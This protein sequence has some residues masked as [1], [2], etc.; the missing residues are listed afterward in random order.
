MAT[1]SSL[2]IGSGVNVSSLISG[3]MA[4]EQAPLTQLSK[5][6]STVNSKLS[7]IGLVKSA[8]SA[9]S[10]A[11]DKL[12]T[13]KKLAGFTTDIAKDASGTS[14]AS[15]TASSTASAGIYNIEITQ[16]A[17][18]EKTRSNTTY[19]GIDALVGSG[20]FV[21]Q[22]GSDTAVSIDVNSTTTL[23]DLKDAINSNAN[24][25]VTAA[26]VSGDSGMKLVLTA[27]DA[28]KAVT[29]SGTS[30]GASGFT[31]IT[32]GK[33]AIVKIDGE[34]VTSG[35]NTIS[36][37]LTGIE[38]KLD[39]VGTTTLTV[40]ADNSTMKDAI[41]GFVSAY[42]SLNTQIQTQSKY[43]TTSKKAAALTGDALL[44]TVKGQMAGALYTVP[45]GVTGSYKNLSEIGISFQ[46][47]GSLS[48]DSTKFDKALKS[49]SDSVMSVLNNYSGA[50]KELA[51]D[52]TASDGVFTQKTDG[53]NSM[54]KDISSRRT[55]LNARLEQI[56]ERYTR[57]FSSMDT[58]V[59]SMNN[60]LSYISKLYS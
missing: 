8:V 55:A 39:K 29:T 1:I 51:T 20:T 12:T 43:D 50:V 4:V 54:L 33:S 27:K 2:G 13:A 41:N 57:Q 7:A 3:L 23:G 11:A 17:A 42:N 38:L 31:T 25:G 30:A 24:M 53:L 56:Q 26:V 52:M 18:Q 47:D 36:S 5:K 10:T 6:E 58:T 16:L 48:F 15:A 46:K 9:L 49:D 40:S 22:S 59:A 19:S 44:S 14:I 37:A 32:T 28:G 60:T 34:T 35:S 21:V 45:S